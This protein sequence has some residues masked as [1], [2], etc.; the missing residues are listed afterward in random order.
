MR[1]LICVVAV[2]AG[3][4]SSALTN[5]PTTHAIA[6]LGTR[7]FVHG[8]RLE[9][10]AFSKKGT[11][12]FALDNQ[13]ACL[14]DVASG[15]KL[16]AWPGSWIC[17]AL[18]TDGQTVALAA[19]G[20][21]IDVFDV[22]SGNMTVGLPLSAGRSSAVALSADGRTVAGFDDADVVLWSVP[23][24]KEVRRWRQVGQGIS[25]L[26]F[27]PG[28]QRLAVAGSKGEMSICKVDGDEEAISLEGSTG[29]RA[30]LAGSP[31][32]KTLAGSCDIR[33]G[34]VTK[35]S[36]RFW[37]TSTGR[38]TREVPGSFEAGDF[39][40][41]GQWLA[42]S[43]LDEVRIVDIVTGQDLQKL[44]NCHEHVRAVAFSPDGKI[45][46]TG[47]GQR[48]RFWDTKT[49]KEILPGTGHVGAVNAVAFSPDGHTIATGGLDGSLILWSWPEAR[50]CR[51]VEGVGSSWGVQHI[52]FS[53]DGRTVGASAWINRDDT[54]FLFDAATGAPVSRFGKGHQG[55]GQVV[56]LPGGKEILTTQCDGSLAV[57]EAA[58]GKLLRSIGNFEKGVDAVQLG[59]D[60][61]TAWWIGS[62]K[63]ALRNLETGKEVLLF[64]TGLYTYMTQT[65]LAVSPGGNLV[66]VGHRLWD[67]KTGEPIS[68]GLE[69]TIYH[70]FEK[71]STISPDGRLFAFPWN[72]EIVLWD[73]LAQAK[74]RSL[75]TGQEA[76]HDLSFSPDATVL[77]AAGDTGVRIWDMTGCLRDGHL[78]QIELKPSEIDDLWKALAGDDATAADQAIWKLAAGGKA[79]IAYLSERLHPVV[80]PDELKVKAIRGRLTDDDYD[81]RETAARTLLDF[82]MALSPDERELLRRPGPEVPEA[83][84]AVGGPPKIRPRPLLPVPVLLPLPE[85]LQAT[86]VIAV[87]EHSLQRADAV[88]VLA[89]LV[90][91]APDAPVTRE[92]KGALGRVQS[93][94][95]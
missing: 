16:Q 32:G 77:A 20:A 35:S 87:L 22:K 21:H 25:A 28:D 43:G 63:L 51:R 56:F 44:S 57:W 19:N 91:G 82:G 1:K 55:Q 5:A 69:N 86:R 61:D 65:R 90:D 15:Q 81:V 41:D 83:A 8:Q 76:F 94:G 14:W 4:T 6:T 18:S 52:A 40:P 23:S 26:R 47:Q 45:L 38:V 80:A 11:T 2:I 49:W 42:A 34:R 70:G 59:V 53:A 68:H 48:I 13:E 46:A 93:R 27:L 66:A 84:R 71:V 74:L 31:D 64:Q 37:D 88:K 75:K 60:H 58:S 95:D 92:A 85:R 39:S 62:D 30:W 24:G 50:E 17:G 29:F 72:G 67:A 12:I 36:L 33:E 54:F 10:L 9:G 78:R 89:R 73:T 3:I 7:S 79:V